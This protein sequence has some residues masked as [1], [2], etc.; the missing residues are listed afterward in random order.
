ISSNSRRTKVLTECQCALC[1][2]APARAKKFRRRKRSSLR[3]L[4]GAEGHC[5]LWTASQA[6]GAVATAGGQREETVRRKVVERFAMQFRETK[7][8]RRGVEPLSAP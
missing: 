4:S 2:G 7:V 8:P 3:D 1:S 5:P 6:N